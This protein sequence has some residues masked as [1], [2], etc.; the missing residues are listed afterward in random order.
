MTAMPH[1][2]QTS[3]ITVTIYN[4]SNAI[5]NTIVKPI[6][7]VPESFQCHQMLEDKAY[8]LRSK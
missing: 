6:S 5:T 8:L 7:M 2:L 3:N 4:I 1:V